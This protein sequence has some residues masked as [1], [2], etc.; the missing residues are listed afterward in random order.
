MRLG[1]DVLISGSDLGAQGTLTAIFQN[2]RLGVVR[3]LA[4]TPAP[5][6]LGVHLP[7]AAENANVMSD[8][9]IGVYAVALRVTR[10]DAPEWM[11]NEVP[12]ALA[13]VI[14]VAPPNAAP[15]NVNLTVTCAPRLR[16]EQ[17]P[18]VLLIFGSSTVAPAA[19]T[20][21]ADPQQP[22]TI[23]FIVPSVTPGTYI[24]RLRVEDRQ[25]AGDRHRLATETRVRSA[26]E[27]HGP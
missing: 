27:G 15:G 22:T 2:V 14:T 20:T 9:A 21:P 8:W 5:R 1:D 17:E 4:P 3:E 16:P 13:P 19:I 7:S 18:R 12:A 11:T 23:D 25:H 26:A 10:P 6:G 24:V